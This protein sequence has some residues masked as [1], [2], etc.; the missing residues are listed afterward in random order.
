MMKATYQSLPH[1]YIELSELSVIFNCNLSHSI[2]LQKV[3]ITD[4]LLLQYFMG[5]YDNVGVYIVEFGTHCLTVVVSPAKTIVYET[6]PNQ[7]DPF[8]LTD[9]NL[10]KHD[11]K[12]FTRAYQLIDLPFLPPTTTR[13]SRK[14]KRKKGNN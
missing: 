14:R 13:S 9:E 12:S 6:D 11:I 3:E 8:E 2:E 4:S 1:G 5:K 7:R 10:V